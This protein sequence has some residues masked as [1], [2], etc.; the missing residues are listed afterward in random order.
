M[1]SYAI[2][3]VAWESGLNWYFHAKPQAHTLSFLSTRHH[4]YAGVITSFKAAALETAGLESCFPK[5]WKSFTK[6]HVGNASFLVHGI[7]TLL[8][9]EVWYLSSN[10]VRR[11]KD[12]R[13]LGKR[14]ER[15]RLRDRRLVRQTDKQVGRQRKW[16]RR[17]GSGKKLRDEK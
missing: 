6:I 16:E 4:L 2:E 15:Q 3:N 13:K 7:H 5:F 12:N 8:G 9:F 17:E 14:E 10:A 1:Q 11:R